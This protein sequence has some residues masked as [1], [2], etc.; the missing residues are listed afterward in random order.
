MPRAGSARHSGLIGREDDIELLGGLLDGEGA[1]VLVLSGEP[2]IGKTAL[3]REAVALAQARGWRV[4]TAAPVEAEGQLS[5]AALADILGGSL[6][7][8]LGALPAPLRRALEVALL[9]RDPSGAHPEPR[10]VAAAGSAA[11]HALAQAGPLLIAVDDVQWL[12]Q[13]SAAVLGFALRRL[14]RSPIRSVLTCRS[15]HGWPRWL[16]PDPTR[17]AR[18]EVGPLSLAA[19]HRVIVAALGE[20]VSRATLRRIYEHAGGNPLYALELARA[21]PPEGWLVGAPDAFVAPHDLATLVRDR[22]ARLPSSSRRTLLYLAALSHPSAG[23][24]RRACQRETDADVA[25]AMAAGLVAGDESRLRFAHPLFAS[26][27]YRSAAGA[28]RRQVHARLAELAGVSEERAHHLAL[29]A[30]GPDPE[31]AAAVD[32]GAR[33]AR[34]RGAPQA[35]AELAELARRLTP[36]ADQA[37]LGR[38]TRTLARYLQEGG[39]ANLARQVLED[40]IGRLPPGP[41][42]ARVLAALA[43][44]LYEQEGT[45]AA[46]AAARQAAGEA[47]DEPTARAEAYL[48]LAGR[49]DLTVEDRPRYAQLALDAVEADPSAPPELVA[50]ALREVALAH[51]HAG[52]GMPVPLLHRAAAIEAEL[53]ERPPVAWRAS[54]ILGECLKYLDGFAEAERLLTESQALAE[55]EGDAGSLGEILGHR[56]ELALWLGHV[57]EAADLAAG[58]IEATLSTEQTGRLGTAYYFRSLVRAHRG[59]VE[60]A[61]SDGQAALAAGEASSP[62]ANAMAHSCLGFLELSLGDMAAAIHHLSQTD[63]FAQAGVVTEPRQWRY[64]ADYVEALLAAGQGDQARCRLRRLERWARVMGTAWPAVLAARSRALVREALGD[65]KASLAAVAEAMQAHASLPLPFEWARTC[66]LAGEIRRRAGEKRPAR[67]ALEEALTVFGQVDAPL[68]AMRARRELGRIS[69]RP[70]ASGA[71]TAS[72][73]QVARLVAEGRSNKEVAAALSIT[74]RTVEA[75]LTRIYG[76]LGVR[77]RTELARRRP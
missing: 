33:D 43:A 21:L 63:R 9:L 54:T 38:R 67:E 1:P 46:G 30:A 16:D 24:L 11:L 3:W 49:S 4:L 14:D 19:I 42:R 6:A 64:L 41:E 31:V 57:D 15:G 5:F 59:E 37:S 55:A 39:D 71:L 65:R 20:P 47:G 70:A 28:A 8:A 29:A 76:K 66:L 34:S 17:T 73:R 52:H 36:P 69:G 18:L 61:R 45:A 2:G 13:P 77:S 56:A 26:V 44:I 25:A 35:A 53:P 10:A 51:Y 50:T 32:A 23:L 60:L 68:W 12:D 72:E 48:A 7:E 22:L 58:S 74:V 75:H 27:C 40:L 62:W